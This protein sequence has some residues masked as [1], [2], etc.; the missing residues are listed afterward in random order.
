M[1]NEMEPT[2]TN[3]ELR[4]FVGKKADYYLKQFAITQD[5]QPLYKMNVAA[6]LISIFWLFYRKMYLIG[7]LFFLAIIVEITISDF[8]FINVLGY[9]SSPKMY[10]AMKAIMY[11]A[12][13][14]AFANRWYFFHT[15]RKISEIKQRILADDLQLIAIKTKGGTSIVASILGPVLLLASALIISGI[16]DIVKKG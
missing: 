8:I 13:C 10:D 11:P 14:A 6:F 2:I 12:I 5:T 3:E 7:M 16:I 9:T 15:K 1:E 4:L